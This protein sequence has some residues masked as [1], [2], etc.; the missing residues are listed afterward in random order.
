MINTYT[1]TQRHTDTNTHHRHTLSRSAH[2]TGDQESYR[3][4]QSKWVQLSSDTERA[5][6]PP[7]TP[8]CSGASAG[9]AGKLTS[10]LAN[11]GKAGMIQ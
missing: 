8:R 2:E 11:A 7:P 3:R 6:P 9:L 10:P 1:H 5:P 4:F